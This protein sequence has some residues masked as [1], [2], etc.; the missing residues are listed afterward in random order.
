MKKTLVK[1][2]VGSGALA[3]VTMTAGMAAAQQA[4]GNAMAAPAADVGAPPPAPAPAAPTGAQPAANADQGVGAGAAAPAS[5]KTNFK[6][7]ALTLNPLSFI[8]TR[9]GVNIEYLPAPHHGIMFNPY[10][11]HN[12]VEDTLQ[13]ETFST[14]GA[15]LGYH[16]YTGS[17][18]ADGFFVG[19]QLVFLHATDSY[20]CKVQGCGNTSSTGFTAYGVALDLGGQHVFDNGFTI[21]GGAG[22]M[23]LKSSYSAGSS[24]LIKFDGVIPRILFMIGY[25]F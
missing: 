24:T 22:V 4:D 20:S 15:E 13:K 1:F 11:S 19:P 9:F 25:S 12:S 14:F 23:Y 6:P 5:P 7:L 17:K 2:A 8:L 18:G 3:L 21:G 10:F 16:F